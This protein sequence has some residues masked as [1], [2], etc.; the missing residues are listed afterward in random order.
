MPVMDTHTL[1]ALD[2]AHIWHPFTPMLEQGREETPV[3]AAAEGFHLIDTDGRRYLDGVSSL[4]CNLHGHRVP[5]IDAA[6]RA[7]LD[8]VAHSTLLGLSNEPSIRFAAALVERVPAG[9]NHLFYSDNGS[10]AVEAALKIAYQ[11]HQQRSVGPSR[12]ELFVCL[13]GGYHGDTIGSVSVGGIDLFHS[14]YG[15]LL[16]KTLKVPA[17]ASFWRPAGMTAADWTGHVLAELERTIV[18]HHSRIAGFVIEPLVQGAA[19]VL[20]HPA[21]YLKRVRDLTAAHDIPLIADEVATGFGRTGTLFACEHEQV[22]PDILCLSKGIT[23]GYLPLAAT[24]VTD[25]IYNAF[26]AEPAEGKTFFHGHTYTGNPLA[27]AAALA[28]LA[29]FE[30]NRVLD[31]VQAISARLSHRLA[32]WSSHRNI[33]EIRQKGVMVGIQLV[34]DRM[35]QTPFP[36]AARIGHRIALAARKRGVVIRPIGEILILMPAPAMPVELVDTLCTIT[37]E[38]IDEGVNGEW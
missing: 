9:L 16:F 4:W 19:G 38:A 14:V 29:L 23:G 31:N 13:S 11:Y 25:E 21:G 18:E 20:V 5:E 26:L 35:A 8:R 15:N 30:S 27:C 28:S 2:N 7:Q 10:T 34:Q 17:P 22:R 32:E 24:L 33:G 3:I 6:I 37:F 36:P 12:R 1:R